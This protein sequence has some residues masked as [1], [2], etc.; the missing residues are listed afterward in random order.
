MRVRTVRKLAAASMLTAGLAAWP[1][2][3]SETPTDGTPPSTVKNL[4]EKAGK[5][6][7]KVEAAGAKAGEAVEKAGVKAVEGTGK[8]MVEAGKNLETSGKEAVEKHVGEKAA[9]AV[10]GAGK[11]L[12]KAGEKIQESVKKKD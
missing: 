8:A 2:C 11:G 3:G 10:E 7:E 4:E 9:A 5:A 1:G 12:E 6:L